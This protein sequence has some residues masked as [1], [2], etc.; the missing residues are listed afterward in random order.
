MN[1]DHQLSPYAATKKAA[2]AMAYTY[3]FLHG[4]DVSVLRYLRFTD[5][6]AGP[7]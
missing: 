7:T 4:L 2:E 3:H 5:R 6:R 1:T